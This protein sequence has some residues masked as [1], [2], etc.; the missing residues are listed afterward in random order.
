MRVRRIV[1][2]PRCRPLGGSLSRRFPPQRVHHAAGFLRSR[3]ALRSRLSR[4][5][6]SQGGADS[7]SQGG[8]GPGGYGS[9]PLQ[10]L[11]PLLEWAATSTNPAIPRNR[12]LEV[13][14]SGLA[15][16]ARLPFGTSVNPALAQSTWKRPTK[17]ITV[18]E[19][20]ACPFC[21]RV[22]EAAADL[23]L[24]LRILP[25]PKNGR[26]FRTRAVEV[27]GR[28]QFPLMVDENN[29]DSV[30]I[31]ESDAIVKYLYETYGGG[32]EESSPPRL[33]S[34][35]LLTGWMPTVLRLGRGLRRYDGAK[36]E[37]AGAR[38]T[39]WSYENNQFARLVR[40][41]LCELE[42]PYTLK[43]CAKGSTK[44]EELKEL[45]GGSTKVPFLVDAGTGE[46]VQDSEQA[47]AYLFKE[48]SSPPPEEEI[49]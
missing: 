3:L 12:A 13:L 49:E 9:S 26:V 30:I 35:T 7:G 29:S 43:A 37:A 44:R 48:Y 18:Y 24:D 14:T 34:S 11:C 32:Y 5:S 47:V 22:R 45:Q 38:I 25:C 42:I 23:D 2:A 36:P 40:E 41:A 39:F 4:A 10:Y 28:E 8:G 19:F 21:R 20:E 27:G 15:S 16:V 46:N 31:Y 33:L 6:S 1:V 17:P